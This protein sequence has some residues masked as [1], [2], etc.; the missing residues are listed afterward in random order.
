VDPGLA[1]VTVSIFLLDHGL[2]VMW[3]P[4][5]DDSA[6]TVSIVSTGLANRYASADRTGANANFVR[7]VQR[8]TVYKHRSLLAHAPER[9][10]DE[11]TDYND[12]I[13]ATTPPRRSRLAARPSFESG[14]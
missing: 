11:T 10:H 14:G 13:Y 5:L 7:P 1:A 3:L 8:C 4:L 6:L 12:M 2:A 9:M